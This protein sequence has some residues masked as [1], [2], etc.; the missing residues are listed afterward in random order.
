[1]SAD[2]ISAKGVVAVLVEG[3]RPRDLIRWDFLLAVDHDQR[4]HRFNLAKDRKEFGW[5]VGK[6]CA[7]WVLRLVK[8]ASLRPWRT[9]S[10]L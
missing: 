7:S 6:C 5:R 2:T 1:M 9:R 10:S 4:G 3:D 8:T